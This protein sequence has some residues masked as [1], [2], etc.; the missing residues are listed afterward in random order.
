M[1]QTNHTTCI[2]VKALLTIYPNINIF[3]SAFSIMSPVIVILNVLL[4]VSMIATKQATKNTS[5]LLVIC[6]SI[7]D[8]ITGGINFPMLAHILLNTDNKISCISAKVASILGSSFGNLSAIITALIAVDRYLHMNPNIQD[9]PSMI[10]KI[11]K[12]SN[13][14]YLVAF[15]FIL[16]LSVS[17]VSALIINPQILAFIYILNF[18]VLM[19]YILLVTFFYVK[20]YKRISSFAN[21]NPV[22]SETGV[23]PQ[24]VKSLYKTVLV[25]VLLV[26]AT[27]LPYSLIQGIM[28]ILA[29]LQVPYTK[30]TALMQ[31]VAFTQLILFSGG[32]TNCLVVL[33][34]NK[35]VKRWIFKKVRIRTNDSQ[36][37]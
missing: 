11:F 26:C 27:Y 32:F 20:G 29:A 30:S 24:Y 36:E 8:L 19:I 4:I 21:D 34:N 16:I 5:N 25:L 7:S 15:I 17:V 2:F 22:Y 18:T 35:K 6:L 33:Y 3:V 37:S 9:R 14:P 12:L 13:I 1:N 28:V 31:F 23:H 10:Y